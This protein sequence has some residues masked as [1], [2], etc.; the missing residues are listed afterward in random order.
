MEKLWKIF[1]NCSIATHGPDMLLAEFGPPPDT[2]RAC[3][4]PETDG[5]SD[6]LKSTRRLK[7]T[8]FNSAVNLAH[9]FAHNKNI[10]GGT[11]TSKKL[12]PNWTIYPLALSTHAV[13]LASIPR[14]YKYWRIKGQPWEL[15]YR[16]WMLSHLS[17]AVHSSRL[18]SA[19]RTSAYP[20]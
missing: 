1:H 2:F 8:T 9:L 18:T 3:P 17:S 13:R 14:I 20:C 6:R 16:L 4:C 15:F 10:T 19:F 7:R 12:S 5:N 11:G